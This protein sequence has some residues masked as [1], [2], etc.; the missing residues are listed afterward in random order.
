LL[1]LVGAQVDSV[2]VPSL[3]ADIVFDVAIRLV[4]LPHD[5]ER[6]CHLEVGLVAPTF[7]DLGKLD[8]E[9]KPRTPGPQYLPGSEMNHHLM[10]RIDFEAMEYGPHHLEFT[11]DGKAQNRV[12]TVLTVV[13]STA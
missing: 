4:G 12:N 3:P 1:T 8:I 7:E 11:L 5:F 13:A 9:V 2:I 10:A 6:G